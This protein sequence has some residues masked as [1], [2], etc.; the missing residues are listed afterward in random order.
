[1]TAALA[2]EGEIRWLPSGVKLYTDG[3][4]LLTDDSAGNT[5]T[6]S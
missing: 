2:D 5:T 1:M 6:L 4:E 3:S